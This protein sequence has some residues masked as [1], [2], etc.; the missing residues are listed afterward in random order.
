MKNYP[1]NT[2]P[3]HAP[4]Y[5]ELFLKRLVGLGKFFLVLLIVPVVVELHR[6]PM[7]GQDAAR[8][9]NAQLTAER[10][11]MVAKRDKLQ[12]QV[13]WLKNDHAYLE[14]RAR[15]HEHMHKK[16]EYIIR[17]TH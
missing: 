11:A 2:A 9:K 12:R 13:A 5:L 14:L 1:E 17:F 6:R 4:A 3:Q 8:A 15:D 16:G 10:D 7:V